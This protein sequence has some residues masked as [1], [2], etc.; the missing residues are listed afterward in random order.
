MSDGKYRF[1]KFNQRNQ[2]NLRTEGGG[3]D[4]IYPWTL[5]GDDLKNTVKL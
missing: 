4:N 5:N 2:D 3:K 1:I